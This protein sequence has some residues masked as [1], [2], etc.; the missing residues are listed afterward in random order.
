M[1]ELLLVLHI[2]LHNE[3]ALTLVFVILR[4]DVLLPFWTFSVF[5]LWLISSH[6]GCCFCLLLV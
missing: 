2:R 4:V 3:M 6:C 5:S 1:S